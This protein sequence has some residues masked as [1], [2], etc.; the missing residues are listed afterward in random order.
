METKEIG[1]PARIHLPTTATIL[2]TLSD[3][4][5]QHS[6]DRK[7]SELASVYEVSVF[8]SNVFEILIFCFL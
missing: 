4:Y 8:I 3:L 2:C 7:W 6:I 1:R 5:T